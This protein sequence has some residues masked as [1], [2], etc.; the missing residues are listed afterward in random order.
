ME[1]NRSS[2]DRFSTEMQTKVKRFSGLLVYGFKVMY[3]GYQLIE[4][5]KIKRQSAQW[6]YVVDMKLMN[7]I[8]LRYDR[9]KLSC[10]REDS[11]QTL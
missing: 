3:A 2:S 10:E 4:S 11:Y 5:A 7:E 8:W 9:E 1:M 6:L